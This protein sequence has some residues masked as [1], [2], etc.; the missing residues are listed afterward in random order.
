VW[1]GEPLSAWLNNLLAHGVQ[2]VWA[3]TWITDDEMLDELVTH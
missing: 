1:V 2:I 3:T